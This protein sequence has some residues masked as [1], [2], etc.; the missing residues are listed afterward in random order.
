M[1][2]FV[3]SVRVTTRGGLAGAEVESHVWSCG[4]SAD[5]SEG[6]QA[7]GGDESTASLSRSPHFSHYEDYISFK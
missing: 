3:V 4:S 6:R 5:C 2:I 1:C 7:E